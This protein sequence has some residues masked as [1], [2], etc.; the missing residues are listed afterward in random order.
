M[1]GRSFMP[2]LALALALAL[3]LLCPKSGTDPLSEPDSDESS[4]MQTQFS[5]SHS[6]KTRGNESLEKSV[7]SLSVDSAEKSN[8]SSK[9]SSNATSGVPATKSATTNT[10]TNSSNFTAADCIK[11]VTEYFGGKY[12]CM[13]QQVCDFTVRI[14]C[15]SIT[16]GGHW[17]YAPKPCCQI[18]PAEFGTGICEGQCTVTKL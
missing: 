16:P 14:R 17:D 1:I 4:L 12:P 2:V 10:T 5:V 13:V 15:D 3:A 9:T 18:P 6:S 11:D 7:K 8:M